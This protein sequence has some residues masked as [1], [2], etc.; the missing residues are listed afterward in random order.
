[1]EREVAVVGLGRA[2]CLCL[3]SPYSRIEHLQPTLDFRNIDNWKLL[4]VPSHA[5]ALAR[6]QAHSSFPLPPSSQ[7]PCPR[8]GGEMEGQR[9]HAIGGGGLMG[10]MVAEPV[11][12]VRVWGFGVSTVGELQ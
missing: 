2:T 1:V 10:V 4:C 6:D 7:C 5:M 11:I 12:D 9:W 8:G 3:P